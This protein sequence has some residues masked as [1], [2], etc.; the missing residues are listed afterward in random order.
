MHI[1]QN[2]EV[3]VISGDNA[4]DTGRVLFVD[5]KKGRVVVEGVN[6]VFKHVRRSQDNP[7]GGRIEKEAPIAVSNVMLICSNRNCP[8][9]GQPVRARHKVGDDGVKTRICAKCGNT[10]GAV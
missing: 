10:I 9:S 3:Q 7:Q 6:R 4:G 8:K 1:R 2:D 5:L